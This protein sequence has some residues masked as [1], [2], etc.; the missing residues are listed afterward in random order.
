MLPMKQFRS[1]NDG[2]KNEAYVQEGVKCCYC[3]L[4]WNDF[5]LLL[6]KDT[7]SGVIVVNNLTDS[8]RGTPTPSFGNSFRF[9]DNIFLL[10]FVCLRLWTPELMFSFLKTAK[11]I[12]KFWKKLNY[13][14]YFCS[15]TTIESAPLEIN[16]STIPKGEKQFSRPTLA[17][18]RDGI[19]REPTEVVVEV[20]V[21][22]CVCV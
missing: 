11:L 2:N 21:C 7:D 12:V 13:Y 18:L 15:K 9:V 10:L 17:H 1:S 4:K 6:L 5:I 19:Y 8:G 16:Y 22:V 3:Y 14:Y 20:C